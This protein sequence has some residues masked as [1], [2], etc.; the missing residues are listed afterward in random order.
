M[1]LYLCGAYQ[2]YTTIQFIVVLSLNHQIY[3]AQKF[4]HLLL[5][6][7]ISVMH[8]VSLLL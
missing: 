6:P 7:V 4:A 5:W 3:R 2:N 8:W 1:P